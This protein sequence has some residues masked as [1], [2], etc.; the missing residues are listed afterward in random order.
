MWLLESFVFHF[1]RTFACP[2]AGLRVVSMAGLQQAG[3]WSHDPGEEFIFLPSQL[4]SG[5]GTEGGGGWGGPG[6]SSES[7]GAMKRLFDS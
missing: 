2:P 7:G 3:R 5:P 6:L 1:Y 4:S